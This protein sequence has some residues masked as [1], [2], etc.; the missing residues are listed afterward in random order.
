[1]I[2]EDGNISAFQAL[3]SLPAGPAVQLIG[4]QFDEELSR[5]SIERANKS[6]ALIVMNIRTD[7]GPFRR[8]DATTIPDTRQRHCDGAAEFDRESVCHNA[9]RRRQNTEAER[10]P[11]GR[12]STKTH[13][14]TC[15]CDASMS[16]QTRPAKYRTLFE[17]HV[18]SKQTTNHK[19]PS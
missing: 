8:L 11:I 1:M 12:R 14:R 19:P 6:V 15:I 4:K 17:K 18:I 9:V 3:Y 2:V 7:T 16:H 13:Q 10:L 5:Y